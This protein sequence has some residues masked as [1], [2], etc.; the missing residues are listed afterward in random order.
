[1]RAVEDWGF[2]WA[3]FALVD[4]EIIDVVLGALVT[5]LCF[6]VEIVGEEAFDA[7]TVFS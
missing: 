6:K 7:G 1:L 2:L 3:G 5:E 4:T